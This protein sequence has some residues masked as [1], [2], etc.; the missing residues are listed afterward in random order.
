VFRKIILAIAALALIGVAFAVYVLQEDVSLRPTKSDPIAL[1]RQDPASGSAT[2]PAQPT[3]AYQSRGQAIHIP[4]GEAPEIHVYDPRTGEARIIMRAKKWEPKSETEF[5]LTE[6]SARVLLQGGQLAYVR[7]DGALIRMPAGDTKNAVPKSGTFTGNVEIFID[8]T[9]P[10]WRREHPDLVAPEQHPEDIVKIWLD[11]VSFD[12]DL[13]RLQSD[14]KVI[15]QSVQ[16]SLEGKGLELMWSEAERKLLKL[17]I[18]QG[19]RAI[20]R[21]A[22]IG[23]VNALGESPASQPADEASASDLPA[24]EPA[25][26]AESQPSTTILAESP[27]TQPADS[28]QISFLD[29]GKRRLR[30]DR[31]DTYEVVFR[32]NIEARQMDGARTVGSL[33]ADVITLLRDFGREERS[34]VEYSPGKGGPEEPRRRASATA[35][36]PADPKHKARRSPADS[37]A[38]IELTWTG[39]VLIEPL[40]SATTQEA[41]AGEKK[42]KRFLLSAKGDPVEMVDVKQGRLICRSFEYDVESRRGSLGG[43]H[44]QPVVLNAGPD[45]QVIVE[46]TL[47]FDQRKGE[48][49]ITGP[50]RLVGTRRSES[51]SEPA[52]GRASATDRLIGGEGEMQVAWQEAADIVFEQSE[53]TPAKDARKPARRSAYLKAAHFSGRVVAGLADQSVAADRLDIT[54]LPPPPKATDDQAKVASPLLS[55]DIVG[56]ANPDRLTAEGRVRMTQKTI[57]HRRPDRG[58]LYDRETTEALSCDRLDV[59]I[60][61]DDTGQSYPRIGKAVG[62]VL[63]RQTV[64]P[65]LGEYKVGS[66]MVRDIRASDFMTIEMASVQRLPSETEIQRLREQAAARGYTPESP[67]WKAKE[68]ELRRRRT[69]V[70]K[71]LTASRGVFAQDAQQN[72]KGLQGETLECTFD[73]DQKIDKALLTGTEE[74]P[75]YVEQSNFYIRGRRLSLDM[76]TETVDVPGKGMLRFHTDQDIDGR[77]LKEKVPVVVDWDDQ[78]WMRGKENLGLFQGNVRVTSENNVME[79]KELRLRFAPVARAN[80]PAATRPADEWVVGPLLDLVRTRADRR[81]SSAVG[82]RRDRRLTRV[83]AFSDVVIVSSS[84]APADQTIGGKTGRMLADRL[85]AFL[86]RTPDHP[87]EPDKNRLLS[88]IRLTGPQV[89][90]DLNENQLLV[91]GKGTLLIEDYRIPQ[92]RGP[93]RGSA[94]TLI[95]S[96]IVPGLDSLGPSQTA[97]AWDN[98]MSFLSRDNIATFDNNVRM[99]HKSGTSMVLRDQVQSAI[100]LDKATLE[101]IGSRSASLTCANLVAQFKTERTAGMDAG[102]SPLSR[103]TGLKGF[104]ARRNVRLT[105]REARVQRIAEGSLIAYDS[106]SGEA[107][108]TGTEQTPA[109]FEAIDAKTGRPIS[110]RGQEV[111]WN[112]KTG[113]VRTQKSQI[114]A[115]GR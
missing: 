102:P 24:G 41:A 51:P 22:A 43:T 105:D 10:E 83:D 26:S 93:R 35:T 49:R 58:E 79:A 68:A 96:A 66:P 108:I 27:A 6:P 74:A 76:A 38:M 7:S 88:R 3:L 81:E 18:V 60:A 14:G 109:Y 101:R 55:G 37:S 69:L 17:R 25:A 12:M 39:E 21:G 100:N 1:R 98:S 23:E 85:P 78:M 34:A 52:I 111:T 72:L 19:K 70:R 113:E 84:Y 99:W 16:G 54:F 56:G 62:R 30:A 75:A 104:W 91:E 86:L 5:V 13:A 44:Q 2:Q 110:W 94:D 42:E 64:Q 80:A 87:V 45:R 77:S 32:D 28:S 50:G 29:Q 103:A 107:K 48:I 115:P 20:I 31:I 114:L 33:K 11:E 8:R 95:A 67:E 57:R 36:A 47:S 92:G 106:G 61:R 90:I 65:R 59:E 73:A 63:A 15:V 89:R 97:L 71:R 46:Q 4:P 9:R 82:V 112:L 53:K 40:A